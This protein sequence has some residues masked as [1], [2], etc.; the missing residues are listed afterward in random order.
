MPTSVRV[1]PSSLVGLVAHTWPVAD[2]STPKA[3]VIGF[4]AG[5]PMKD[6]FRA[7]DQ[8]LSQNSELQAEVE[9]AND[10][11]KVRMETAQRRFRGQYLRRLR[12]LHEREKHRGTD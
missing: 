10:P 11:A 6:W 12:R 8:D 7:R 4:P 5:P 2:E 9:G 3:W 1:A